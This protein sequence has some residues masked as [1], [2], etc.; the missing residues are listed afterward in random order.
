MIDCDVC[1]ARA[2]ACVTVEIEATEL[3]AWPEE[4]LHMADT[5]TTAQMCGRCIGIMFA[6]GAEVET[7]LNPAG[8]LA[9]LPLKPKQ[10]N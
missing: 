10:P 7:A 3:G 8:P 5:V 6:K 1:G 9:V 4:L 2:I